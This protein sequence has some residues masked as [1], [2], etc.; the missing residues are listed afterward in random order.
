MRLAHVSDVHVLEP[1]SMTDGYGLDIRFLSFGRRL[2]AQ[3]R[4]RKLARALAAAKRNAAD[5][6]VVS[7]DLTES[8]TPA[9]FE[10]LAAALSAGPYAS[11]L[12]GT[13]RSS[14]STAPASYPSTFRSRS[15]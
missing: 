15:R 11:W 2:D 10:L 4:L 9:Q 1:L 8:A 5:H 14:S 3:G 13:A 12:P 7:G 6:V